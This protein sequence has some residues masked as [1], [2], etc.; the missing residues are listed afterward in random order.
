MTTMNRRRFLARGAALSGSA[1]FANSLLSTFDSAAH[2]TVPPRAGQSRGRW[3]TGGYGPLQAV[4]AANE[5]GGFAYFALPAGFSYVVF[6]KTGTPM[7]TDP[8]LLNPQNHDGMAAFRGSGGL[9]RLT[10]N[11]EDRAAPGAGSV[12]GPE[13]TKYDPLAGGGVTVLDYD[14]RGCRV[15]H[16]FIGI[17]GTHVNCAGGIAYRHAGWITCE[18]T[19]DGPHN[20]YARKHGY[21]FFLPADANSTVDA[22]PLT[23]MGRFAHEAVAVDQHTGTVYLTEDAGSDRGSGFYRF[24][25]KNPARLDRG[26]RLQMLKVRH[27][28]QADLREG[29]TRHRWLQVTWVDIDK[30]DPDPIVQAENPD[31]TSVFAQG[32]AAGGAKF[33]RLEGI[34]AADRGFIFASTSGGDAKTGDVNSDGYAEGYGQIWEYVPGRRRDDGALRLVFESPGGSVLDS[35]DNL[36]IT[37]HGQ[38]LICEDDASSADGDTHPLAPGIEDINRL[39]GLTGNGRTFEFLVNRYSDSELAGVCFSPNGKTVFVNVFGGANPGSGFTA[40]I[41]GPWHQGVL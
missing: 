14:P 32:W 41:T 29:Q 37:P 9:V 34:W 20:G 17:N 40:A 38:L 6:G 18:E 31:A 27:R 23:A 4:T 16:D 12:K 30:P 28:P 7:V 22:E 36:T 13:D 11:H 35:P 3:Y 21:A 19:I 25:P 10:R 26:G 24:L 5:P 15:V 8:S 39:I 2:A 33:N 1:L